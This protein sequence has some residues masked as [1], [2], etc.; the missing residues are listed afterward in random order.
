MS[1]Y[2]AYLNKFKF[3]YQKK[4]SI[5]FSESS[6]KIAE[7]TYFSCYFIPSKKIINKRIFLRTP[8]ILID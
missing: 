6:I 2:N 4:H 3:L 5:P 8:E 7:K 1:N